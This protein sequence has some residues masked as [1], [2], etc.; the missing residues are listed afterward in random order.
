MEKIEAFKN[1]FPLL[2]KRLV[3]AETPKLEFVAGGLKDTLNEIME[4]LGYPP[5]R[6]RDR[7]DRS[8]VDIERFLESQS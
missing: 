1:E 4:P 5:V 6:G 8:L 2:Y 3:E 7:L